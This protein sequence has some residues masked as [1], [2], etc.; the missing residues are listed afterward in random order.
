MNNEKKSLEF[1]RE[2]STAH[3]V[4]K[5]VD[6]VINHSGLTVTVKNIT[7]WFCVNPNCKEIQFDDSTDSL[8]RWAFAGDELVLMSRKANSMLKE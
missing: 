6:V 1:C 3:P 7:G 4:Y 5:T 8:Q 2:F